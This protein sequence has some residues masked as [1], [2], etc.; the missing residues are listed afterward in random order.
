MRGFDDRP[1]PLEFWKLAEE[2][3]VVDAAILI[4]GN[5]PDDYYV[6]PEGQRR[7]STNY[8]GFA[9]TFRALKSAI[10]SNRLRANVRLKARHSSAHWDGGLESYVGD[11]AAE[12]E[13]EVSYDMLMARQESFGTIEANFDLSDFIRGRSI[14]V[15]KEPDWQETTIE[16]DILKEWLKERNFFPPFFFSRTPRDG[17]RDKEHPRYAPKLAACIAA[18]EAVQQSAPNKSVKQTLKDWLRSNASAFGAGDDQG[19][20]SETLANELAQIVNWNPKGGAT[21]TQVREPEPVRRNLLP[22][23]YPERVDLE[24]NDDPEI[25]F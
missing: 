15:A 14:Y 2:L 8:D 13:G 12:N 19:V 18:W 9:A 25:P 11:F 10:L 24:G 6:D 7:Q 17:F 22:N 3:S 23:N 4:T 1:D 20:V 21:P 5:D 16:V